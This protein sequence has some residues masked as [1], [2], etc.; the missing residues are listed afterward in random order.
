M[1]SDITYRLVLNEVN[2]LYDYCTQNEDWDLRFVRMHA[3]TL[4]Q[5]VENST[6][7]AELGDEFALEA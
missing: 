2:L 7:D 4:L 1:G 6:A 5:H 3:L